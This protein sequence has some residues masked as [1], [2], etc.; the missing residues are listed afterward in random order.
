MRKHYIK[1]NVLKE[2]GETEPLYVPEEQLNF[3]RRKL[4]PEQ[5][6]QLEKKLVWLDKTIEKIQ[7]ILDDNHLSNDNEP[8]TDWER[9]MF[10]FYQDECRIDVHEDK[11]ILKYDGEVPKHIDERG[12]KRASGVYLKYVKMLGKAKFEELREDV[13]VQ[14]REDIFVDI[15][16]TQGGGKI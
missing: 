7:K 8:L 15:D 3:V 9:L 2:D 11:D 12:H 13:Y 6:E 14:F 10:Q 16:P 5:R 4:K 1:A